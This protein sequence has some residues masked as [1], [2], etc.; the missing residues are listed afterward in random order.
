[1]DFCSHNAIFPTW[2]FLH[3]VSRDVADS[4]MY[5][6][7]SECPLQSIEGRYVVPVTIRTAI[8]TSLISSSNPE[9]YFYVVLGYRLARY[10]LRF[11]LKPLLR[12]KLLC[13]AR[14]PLLPASWWRWLFLFFTFPNSKNVHYI[15]SSLFE[16]DLE[17]LYFRLTYCWFPHLHVFL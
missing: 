16:T 12:W 3:D 13:S 4:P 8:D 11:N 2:T 5:N 15:L 14:S 1:M 6:P 10:S 17:S 9:K 7:C